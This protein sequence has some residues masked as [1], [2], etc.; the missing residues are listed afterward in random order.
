LQALDEGRDGRVIEHIPSGVV[1]KRGEC[2]EDV[3]VLLLDTSE[4][5]V[6]LVSPGFPVRAQDVVW[7]TL[8]L[9][10]CLKSLCVSTQPFTNLYSRA[11]LA[12]ANLSR[13]FFALAGSANICP[14]TLSSEYNDI[15]Q[16]LS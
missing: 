3:S 13:S 15:E 8:A 16:W 12:S 2:L 9:T 7:R 11:S 14:A 1:D 4:Q 10:I 6:L 5:L